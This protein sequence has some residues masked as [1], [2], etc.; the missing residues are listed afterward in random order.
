MKIHFWGVVW[1]LLLQGGCHHSGTTEAVYEPGLAVHDGTLRL[2]GHPYRGMGVNYF[3]LFQR[4][5]KEHGDI[6]YRR[7]LEDLSRAGIPFVRFMA[8]GFW[9]SDWELYLN[10]RPTYFKLLDDV[11]RCAEH[12]RIGL[13]PSLFWYMATVPDIV[14]EP[15]DQLGNPASETSAFIRRYTAEVVGRYRDSPAIWAWEF[16]NEYNLAVDLPNAD[17]HRPPV[18]PKL[19]TA[20]A[21][22][23]RDE[24]SAAMMLT[25][26][27]TFAG[28]VRTLD[29]RR[30]LITG[31]SIP[32]P[33]AWHNSAERSW[34]EDT[35][36]QF[37]EILKRDNPDPYALLS[38]HL[39]PKKEGHSG[40]CQSLTDQIVLLQAISAR[41]GKPLFIGEFGAAL[42]LGTEEER[43][44]FTEVVDAI[45]SNGV[46]LS[47]MW[48]F[49]YAGQER[50]WNVT[51]DN[52]RAYM[53]RMVAD[54]NQRMQR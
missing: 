39:Y 15:M 1:L 33:H 44:R 12:N 19:K 49:D 10:D 43:I 46:P 24:L 13:I 42:T 9:P 22:S 11:V 16:G 40:G 38:V 31:N 4:V 21:R 29:T 8:C 14:G 27:D 47:A 17:K 50:E 2:E 34:K 23:A 6:S 36:A 48:V 18:W 3:N 53:L 20:L 52:R 30:P 41:A 35:P 28:A 32:R 5:L 45:V 25:A 54:A 51:F 37:E 7:G 26:F